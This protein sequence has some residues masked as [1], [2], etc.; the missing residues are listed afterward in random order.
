[1]YDEFDLSRFLDGEFKSA[2]VSYC[3]ECLQE[4]ADSSIDAICGRITYRGKTVG[5]EVV[6]RVAE[7]LIKEIVRQ[8]YDDDE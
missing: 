2:D 5:R 1:M 3:E 7:E 6:A 4:I 8:T